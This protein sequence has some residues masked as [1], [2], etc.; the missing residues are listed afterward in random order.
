[1]GINL[2]TLQATRTPI[3]DPVF[4]IDAYKELFY[5]E[6]G[7]WR[8]TKAEIQCIEMY[9]AKHYDVD[10]E[11]IV[12]TYN[13]EPA[14][15]FFDATHLVAQI[16][17]EVFATLRAFEDGYYLGDIKL[18]VMLWDNQMR[19][20]A[21]EGTDAPWQ[22]PGDIMTEGEEKWVNVFTKLTRDGETVVSRSRR[23][24]YDPLNRNR[25]HTFGQYHTMGGVITARHQ[26]CAHADEMLQDSVS[27]REAQGG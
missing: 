20:C 3:N 12:L 11:D 19:L 26:E 21:V 18:F 4:D 17:N 13:G 22:R 15:E 7:E 24:K 25:L 23:V 1:M 14:R 16:H 10:I 5:G 6:S 8:P 2:K 9:V 27:D